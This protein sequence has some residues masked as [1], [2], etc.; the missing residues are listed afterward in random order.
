[1]GK[2]DAGVLAGWRLDAA[3]PLPLRP[4]QDPCSLPI[5]MRGCPQQL[6]VDMRLRTHPCDYEVVV[7]C[8]AGFAAAATVAVTAAATAASARGA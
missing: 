6:R 4:R 2:R 7:D 3:G 1:M 5:D 8:P